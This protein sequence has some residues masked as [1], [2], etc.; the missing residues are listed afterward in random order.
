MGDDGQI[1][2]GEAERYGIGGDGWLGFGSEG[3][4]G[5]GIVVDGVKSLDGAGGLVINVGPDARQE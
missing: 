1:G 4:I 2:V 5:V 3:G